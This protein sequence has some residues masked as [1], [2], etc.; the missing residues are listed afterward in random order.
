MFADRKKGND[1][2][3]C[4][5]KRHRINFF[6]PVIDHWLFKTAMIRLQQT[7]AYS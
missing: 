5:E 1:K 6:R 3:C 4:M 7:D 2:D